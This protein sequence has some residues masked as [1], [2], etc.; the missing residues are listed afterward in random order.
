LDFLKGPILAVQDFLA[1]TGTATGL[2]SLVAYTPDVFV[3]A[4]A[5]HLLD[6]YPAG[7]VGYRIFFLI[8]AI[9]AL[10]GAGL[11][12]LFRRRVSGRRAR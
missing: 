6:R 3:P 5:G 12:V 1:L 7:G 8:L 4:L 11:T 2:I 9:F 10:A